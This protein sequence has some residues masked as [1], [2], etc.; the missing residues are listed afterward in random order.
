LDNYISNLEV[1]LDIIAVAPLVGAWI[2]INP[3]GRQ[4]R[5]YCVA[6]SCGSDIGITQQ[7]N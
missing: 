5:S 3:M 1:D 2:E 7:R 4:R 6:P